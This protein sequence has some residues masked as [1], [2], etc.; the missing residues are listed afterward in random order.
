MKNVKKN[1][2]KQLENKLI[3][4]EEAVVL[5]KELQ[6]NE[7]AKN[8]DIAII[9]ASCKL[10]MSNNTEEFWDNLINGRNC[11]V[12][13]P[14]EKL[15]GEELFMNPYYAELFDRKAFKE[16]DR[17]IEKFVGAYIE[18]YDK[19]D[20]NFFNIPPREAKY[21]DPQQRVFLEAA[22]TAI[23]DAGYSINNIKDS[24]T[25]VFVGRDGTNSN[26][27]KYHT[28]YDAMSVS[29][30]WEGI[31]ASRINYIFNLR[32]PSFVV[33]TACSSGLVAIHEACNALR[34]EDCEMAIAGGVSIG[35]GGVN[36]EEIDKG[37]EADDEEAVSSVISDDNRVRAFDSKG[38]GTVFGEGVVAFLLKPLKKAIK[39]K[40]NIYGIIRGSS[41]NSDGASNGLTAPNP[42]AQ[43][44][45][46]VDAWK[47]AK[48]KAEDVSYIESHGTGT[49]LGDPIEILGLKNAFSRYTDRKQFCGIGSVKTNIGHTVGAAGCANVLKVVLAM[50]NNMIPPSLNFEE[51]NPH[52]NFVDS[53]IYVVDKPT[54][55]KHGERAR[56]AGISA[57]GFS[58]T[59]CHLIVEEPGVYADE[60]KASN[61]SNILTLSAK[62]ETAMA[63]TIKNYNIFLQNKENM[64]IDDV[65]FTANTGRGHYEYRVALIVNSFED[66]KNKIAHLINDGIRSIESEQIYYNKSHVVSDKRKQRADGEI[67]GSEVRDITMRAKNIVDT[68]SEKQ[69]ITEDQ[70]YLQD[71]C[72]L[73]VSGADVQWSLLYKNEDVKRVPLPTYPFDRTP[74]WGEKRVSKIKDISVANASGN[75]HPLVEKCLVESM[76]QSIYLVNFSL[77]KHWPLQEHII[78]GRNIVS[79]TT[80]IEILKEAYR[81]YYN[82]DNILF[83]NIVFLL[84]LEVT[85]E[86]EDIETHIIITKENQGDSF[87]VA[88][89]HY[90]EN[91]DVIWKE[92]V[93]GDA[94][95]HNDQVD[96]MSNMDEISSASN[97][98]EFGVVKVSSFGDRWNCVEKNFRV[99]DSDNSVF[100]SFIKLPD[101]YSNDLKGYNYHPGM[102]DDAINMV[103]FQI[104]TGTDFYLPFSYKNMKIF[105]NLP[106][107]FYSKIVKINKGSDSE[108]LTFNISLVD[109]D[110]NV[111]ALIEE[112]AVKKV[113]RFN[114]YIASSYYGVKWERQSAEEQGK[115]IPNGNVLIIKDKSGVADVLS[116]TIKCNDNKLFYVSYEDKYLKLDDTHYII[117]G[118]EEDYQKLLDDIG[119]KSF[120]KVYHLGTIDF[121]KKDFEIEEYSSEMKKGLYSLVYLTKT[122]MKQIKGN[123]DFVLLSEN[124]HNVNGEEEYIK[125]ANASFL[126]IAKTLLHE[127]P[128]FTYRCVDFDSLTEKNTIIGEVLRSNDNTFRV[129]FRNNVRYTE[130]LSTIDT[131]KAK[132]KNVELKT[133]GIYL[134]TGGTG[135]LGLEVALNFSEFSAC[136]ICLLG[137][138]KVPGRTEWE[139]ILEK[140]ENKKLCNLIRGLQKLEANGCNIVIKNGSVSNY[141]EMSKIIDELK[142][143]YG[144][145][146][147]LVHCAGVAGD[148]F[149]YK[150]PME[151]FD[152][153]IN[154]KI[155]GTVILD[156]L[157]RDQKLEFFIMFSSMQTLFGG[158][159]QGDYT[160]ANAFL[161]SYAPFLNKNGVDAQAINWPG[162]SETG[163]A[164]DYN[165][166]EAVTFFK[167]LNTQ[168]AISTFNNIIRTDLSNVVPGKISFE[169]L[170]R[171]G[172]ENLPLKLSA[173]LQRDLKRYQSK[174]ESQN[175]EETRTMISSEDL[176]ILG[177]S[178]EEF[179]EI[180]KQA[181]YIYAVV[182]NLKEIDI[183]ESFSSLGGDSIIATEVLKV[184]NHQFNGV[185]NISDMFTYSC[186]EEMAAY[187]SS[188]LNTST[189]EE[190]KEGYNDIMQK[191]E[192]G[193]IDINSMIDYFDD[194]K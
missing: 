181:A 144:R 48:I 112:C 18:D 156:K 114:N 13:K 39:D 172:E 50:K 110:G 182:L 4:Q 117:S 14:I 60:R 58:G 136:N 36:T 167:S 38:S 46:I 125:P 109:E 162:W 118:A 71:I 86:D 146:I 178:D 24:M 184:L 89:K 163:M 187:I 59:N 116:N 72:K 140:N 98:E 19:F 6:Q 159:G 111:L 23:E 54:E 55:W 37:E 62:T 127:C 83:E 30:N 176:V 157:T 166:S 105:K 123:V 94:H 11:F 92:H 186:V 74:Y 108:V 130:I 52:I 34:N 44:A 73:Y 78:M 85:S 152:N 93:K 84:P 145:I 69:N 153:T 151:V 76:T 191:F 82:S 1:I 139:G 10:P 26:I 185:L 143:E 113:N 169:F 142:N 45:V 101:K 87:L 15:Q 32:G 99:T 28:E 53:P 8:D 141:E 171:I 96:K 134:I 164:A 51:P 132:K 31:L 103:T 22:W 21:I 77:K 3:S 65:C 173:K 66:L 183:Y 7:T 193:D 91:G 188:L 119:V 90:D 180:E 122:F 150:K 42:V 47:R 165:V 70:N 27:Y 25:G 12:T 43:E 175:V 129:A 16:E 190:K 106:R 63:N 29:G 120:S 79:G 133:D 40:D 102:L 97:V 95:M 17:D 9:G 35:A 128:G 154:P 170:S 75:I 5:L 160:A 131:T 88:S 174:N 57:F 33:D 161:D 148:G 121:A 100:Y 49:L 135:G 194:K 149:I 64:N 80:Y 189:K 41:I 168:T 104:F 2:L 177:K 179:T 137:R 147:G 138:S 115:S 107:R 20:A 124:A 158:P 56:I 68:I 61:R 192:S 81:Q 67:S 155:Y 126:S